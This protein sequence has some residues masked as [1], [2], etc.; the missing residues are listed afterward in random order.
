MR[1]KMQ[2]YKDNNE[3]EWLLNRKASL[4]E[5]RC[6]MKKAAVHE[7]ESCEMH[8]KLLYKF[9]LIKGTLSRDFETFNLY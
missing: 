2:D 9:Y 4:R 1:C 6:A 5:G 7:R 8:L 3:R